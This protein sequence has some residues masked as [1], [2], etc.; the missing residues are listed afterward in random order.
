M[1]DRVQHTGAIAL[2]ILAVVVCSASIGKFVSEGS[3]GTLLRGQVNN[4]RI[5]DYPVTQSV[6]GAAIRASEHNF[7]TCNRGGEVRIDAHDL[8]RVRAWVYEFTGNEGSGVFDGDFFVSEAEIAANPGLAQLNTLETFKEGKRYYIM[9]EHDLAFKCG[10]GLYEIDPCGDLYCDRNAGES[11]HNCPADCNTCGDTVRYGTEQCDD[12]N[13]RDDDG[14]DGACSLEQ[15]YTCDT[16]TPNVCT[17]LLPTLPG[18][19]GGNGGGMSST[20][21]PPQSSLSSSRSSAQCQDTDGG[22][23]PN[24][25]GTARF[26][27]QSQDDV[28]DGDT[29]REAVCSM[30]FMETVVSNCDYGCNNGAC[31]PFP[32]ASSQGSS[33]QGS[34]QAYVTEQACIAAGQ[35]W[36]RENRRC[37]PDR[38]VCSQDDQDDGFQIGV[39]GTAYGYDANAT[40]DNA[41]IRKAFIDECVD[42]DTIL[43]SQ[44]DGTY[45]AFLEERD[46]PD[47]YECSNGACIETVAPA[48]LPSVSDVELNV[49]SSVFISS[50]LEGK[51][52]PADFDSNRYK[53]RI[54]IQGP[55]GRFGS[56]MEAGINHAAGTFSRSLSTTQLQ[57][58]NPV[59]LR[60]QVWDNVEQQYTEL[61][62][63]EFDINDSAAKILDIRNADPSNGQAIQTGPSPIGRFKFTAA[64]DRNAAQLRSIIFNVTANGV[65]M[66]ANGFRIAN[67]AEDVDNRKVNCSPFY[68]SGQPF[69]ANNISSAFLVECNLLG[70]NID[71]SI[72]AADEGT[73]DPQTSDEGTTFILEG[74]VINPR[75]GNQAS[76]LQVSLQSFSDTSAQYGVQ[77]NHILWDEVDSRG[78]RSPRHSIALPNGNTIVNSASYS[79]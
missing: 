12:G 58:N 22:N 50:R 57:N 27:G 47:G 35:Y 64:A 3:D 41:R 21:R 36:N 28:C 61:D 77:G 54:Q 45:N 32:P 37:T 52:S 48:T 17:L 42:D 9:A 43:E 53:I 65:A 13:N 75:M 34:S 56:L 29:L 18:G 62:V 23:N 16:S 73:Y 63:I 38:V 68:L 72:E 59:T 69:T 5:N 51:V 30:G 25:F 60:I 46:C 20:P 74:N 40:G 7:V 26:N 71:S 76:L 6:N 31:R 4:I 55:S 44:C 39:A 78:H 8:S 15:W 19:N 70:Q 24:V 10:E 79:N 11:V 33:S 1:K 49:A 2:G 67:A 66:D 14:C